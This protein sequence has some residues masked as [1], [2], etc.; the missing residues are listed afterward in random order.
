M[1]VTVTWCSLLTIYELIHN[2]ARNKKSAVIV[3]KIL[4]VTLQD[5]VTEKI[6]HLGYVNLCVH[7]CLII[8]ILTIQVHIH[9]QPYFISLPD[10]LIEC[11]PHETLHI[12]KRK[13]LEYNT[14]SSSVGLHVFLP[15][16]LSVLSGGK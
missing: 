16:N 9:Q 5:F 2:I 8:S 3:L 13:V 14:P 6:M 7:T 12:F 10:N 11:G 1:N 15:G 4:G